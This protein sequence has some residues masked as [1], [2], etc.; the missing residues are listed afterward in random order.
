MCMESPVFWNDTLRILL[1]VKRKLLMVLPLQHAK[2]AVACP[3]L[4]WQQRESSLVK[5]V[6]HLSAASGCF[7]S[8]ADEEFL[9]G[10]HLLCLDCMRGAISGLTE[11]EDEAEMRA[12]LKEKGQ[13]VPVLAMYTQVLSLYEQAEVGEFDFFDDDI[14]KVKYPIL[15]TSALHP[16]QPDFERIKEVTV[17]EMEKLFLDD[18]IPMEMVVDLVWYT[19]WLC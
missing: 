8:E 5:A 4:S 12:F 11:A 14:K 9:D 3:T 7:M 1:M 6:K 10:E 16:S 2:D 15:P 17:C 13:G 19:F 18:N